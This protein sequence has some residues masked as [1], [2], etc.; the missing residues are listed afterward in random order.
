MN[1]MSPAPRSIVCDLH[2]NCGAKA[3]RKQQ[4]SF[5]MS[6][7]V[8]AHTHNTARVGRD[9]PCQHVNNRIRFPLISMPFDGGA[10]NRHGHWRSKASWMVLNEI[11]RHLSDRPH[12]SAAVHNHAKLPMLELG[13]VWFAFNPTAFWKS[14]ERARAAHADTR[15]QRVDSHRST[16]PT[17][18]IIKINVINS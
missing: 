7:R 8:R 12:V 15:A 16:L 18:D 2:T 5:D 1:P 6:K 10:L 13:E 14:G 9:N 11:Y 4:N 3:K 17:V